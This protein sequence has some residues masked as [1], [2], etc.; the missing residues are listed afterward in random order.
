V[1]VVG[2]SGRV[3]SF[4]VQ[5]AAAAAGATV[6]APGLLEDGTLSVP[7]QASYP[8]AQVDQAL[9]DLAGRHTQGKLAVTLP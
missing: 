2:A 1:L 9:K 4:A 8:L 3:G 7:I 5:L 6:V